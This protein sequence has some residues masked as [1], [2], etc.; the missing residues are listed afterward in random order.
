[1][2][3]ENLPAAPMPHDWT[4]KTWPHDVYPYDRQRARHLLKVHQ[5]TLVKAY[6]LTRIGHEIVVLGEGFARWMAA[7]A[8]RVEEYE[9]PANRPEHAAK[10][11][12]RAGASV[13][14]TPKEIAE[15]SKPTV[16]PDTVAKKRRGA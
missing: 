7:N 1:M 14:A 15:V 16:S 4:L 13:T 3:N 11:F 6:A 5:A 9:V 10:R 2:K 8:K 12:G